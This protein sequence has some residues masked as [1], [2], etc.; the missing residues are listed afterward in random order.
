MWE[1]FEKLCEERGVTAN[2][3]AKATGVPQ[4]TLA[5]W[6]KRRNM[7][8]AKA[9][10][11]LAEYFGVSL[12]YLMTGESTGAEEVVIPTDRVASDLATI[13]HDNP[14]IVEMIYDFAD[15]DEKRYQ[16]L[17]GYYDAIVRNER[18]QS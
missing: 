10:Q 6:K 11:K 3:V 1:I 17:R 5:N 12:Q 18:K 2:A 13:I 9:A 15:I 8:N 4:T 7:L 14:V 16:R